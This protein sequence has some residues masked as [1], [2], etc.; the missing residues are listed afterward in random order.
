VKWAAVTALFISC[1]YY[2]DLASYF[3]RTPSLHAGRMEGSATLTDDPPQ[4][5]ILEYLKTIPKTTM[6]QRLDKGSYTLAPGLVL[7]AGH[8]PFLGWPDHEKVWRGDL[9]AILERDAEVRFF[10]FA[11]LNEPLAWLLK[12]GITH[13]L[14]LKTEHALPA[15]T[16]GRIQASIEGRYGWREFYRADNTHTGLWELRPAPAGSIPRRDAALRE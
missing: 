15:E 11:Q 9:P 1:A 8:N 4:Q 5:A 2:F 6:L 3:F 7:C 10:Y 13:V 14:W 12:S 16:W